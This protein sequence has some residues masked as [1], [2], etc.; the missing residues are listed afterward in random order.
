MEYGVND[1]MNASQDS[2]YNAAKLKSEFKSGI[3]QMIQRIRASLPK[4]EIVLVAPF[5]SNPF[6]H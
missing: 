2:D 1:A 4:C 3:D 6:C 5:Y